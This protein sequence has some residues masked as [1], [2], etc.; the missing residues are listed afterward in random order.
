MLLTEQMVIRM[1]TFL[2]W[3]RLLFQLLREQGDSEVLFKASG[4][5]D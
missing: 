5:S 4:P 1:G 2:C 3:N